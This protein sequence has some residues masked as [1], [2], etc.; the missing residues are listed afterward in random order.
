ASLGDLVIIAAFG[1]VPE[2]QVR[3]HRPKL[4]FVD[5]ANFIKEERAHIPVQAADGEAFAA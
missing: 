2:E 4:V 5:E 1:L 3:G